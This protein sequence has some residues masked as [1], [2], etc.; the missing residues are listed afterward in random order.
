MLEFPLILSALT[1]PS[2][3]GTARPIV[4]VKSFIVNLV[5][6]ELK[7]CKFNILA[8]VNE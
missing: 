1:L 6:L 4:I 8:K 2:N 5:F 7:S 3:T